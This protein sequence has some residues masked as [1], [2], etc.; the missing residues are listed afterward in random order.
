MLEK[1]PKYFIEYLMKGFYNS[2]VILIK[3]KPDV[4]TISVIP[5]TKYVTDKLTTS[6]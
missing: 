1:E 4:L 3:K 6:F 2:I 5:Y